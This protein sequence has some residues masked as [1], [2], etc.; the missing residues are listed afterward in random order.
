[1]S[2]QGCEAATIVTTKK[3]SFYK[4]LHEQLVTQRH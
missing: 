3:A 4:I 2:T 1:M